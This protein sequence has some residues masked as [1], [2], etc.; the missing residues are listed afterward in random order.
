MLALEGVRNFRDFGGWRGL[1]G[2]AVR[3]GR[4]FRSAHFHE[5]TEADMATLDG[6]GAAFIVDLRRPGERAF[7]PNRWPGARVEQVTS[8]EGEEREAPHI[9]FLRNGD[10]TEAG[11]DRFMVDLYRGLPHEARHVALFSGY[12]RRLDATDAA[13]SVV[14]CAAGKDRT[15]LLCALTLDLLGV[16]R[17][18]VFT[19]YLLTN[20]VAQVE[21]KLPMWQAW[22]EAQVGR[23][24]P[25]EALRPFL[26]VRAGYLEAAIAVIEDRHGSLAGYREAVLGVDAAMADRLRAA[27]LAEADPAPNPLET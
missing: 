5:A 20:T 11:V 13:P 2:V 17:E 19:D 25:I 21:R 15:G 6:L 7:Q 12:F 26:G 4:L 8:D 22:I 10:M 16:S 1:D 27:L 3:T 14:H 9:A 18:D 23:H 24:V